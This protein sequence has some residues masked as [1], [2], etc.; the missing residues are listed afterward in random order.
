MYWQDQLI[1]CLDIVGGPHHDIQQLNIS[2]E[3]RQQYPNTRTQLFGTVLL[4]CSVEVLGTEPA[5]N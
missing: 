3:V 2:G 5:S 4:A 1:E